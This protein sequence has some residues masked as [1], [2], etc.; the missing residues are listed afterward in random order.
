LVSPRKPSEKGLKGFTSG[1]ATPEC[2]TK[3]MP[4]FRT[5]DDAGPRRLVMNIDGKKPEASL[6]EDNNL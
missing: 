3:R 1:F 2:A 6:E 4:I 5:F